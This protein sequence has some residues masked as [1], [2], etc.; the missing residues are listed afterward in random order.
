M[1]WVGAMEIV[2]E[3][4]LLFLPFAITLCSETVIYTSF[5][6][7]INNLLDSTLQIQHKYDW[8]MGV[9]DGRPISQTWPA[10]Q[11]FVYR[12]SSSLRT[13]ER[14]ASL[15]PSP[16][17]GS[18]EEFSSFQSASPSEP[19]CLQFIVTIRHRRKTDPIMLPA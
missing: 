7:K 9:V 4:P 16:L 3:I 18:S 11:P 17:A 5:E 15:L 14:L 19:E 12:I 8:P 2:R 10:V 6:R 13:T 1:H